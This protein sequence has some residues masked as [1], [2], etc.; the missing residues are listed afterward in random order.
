M[1]YGQFIPI[2]FQIGAGVSMF[3]YWL[4]LI[5]LSASIFFSK[6]LFHFDNL[7]PQEAV[8]VSSLVSFAISIA[9]LF[10]HTT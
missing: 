9:V 7:N 2:K 4:G 3:A 8:Y 6:T 10:W 1:L 5:A